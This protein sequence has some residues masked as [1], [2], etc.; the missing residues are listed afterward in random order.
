M[1][2]NDYVAPTVGHTRLHRNPNKPMAGTPSMEI[3]LAITPARTAQL[4]N[5][6]RF[7][8]SVSSSRYYSSLQNTAAISVPWTGRRDWR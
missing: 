7:Q 2:K 1:I 6:S 4:H 8:L 5:K 3:S